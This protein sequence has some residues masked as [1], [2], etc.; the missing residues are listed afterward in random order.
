MFKEI[1]DGIQNMSKKQKSKNIT[2][3]ILKIT[4]LKITDVNTVVKS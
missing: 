4:F 2:R 3:H 1:T